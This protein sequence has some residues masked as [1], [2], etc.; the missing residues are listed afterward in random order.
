MHVLRAVTISALLTMVVTTGLAYAHD[1]RL[2]EADAALVKAIALLQAAQ[3]GTVSPK[4]QNTFA[5][6][7]TEAVNRLNHARQQIQAAEQ[8]VDTP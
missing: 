7:I 1:S 8:I 5:K 3:P 4:K 2:D 6:H